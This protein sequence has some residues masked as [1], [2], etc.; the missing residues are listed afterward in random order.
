MLIS[1]WYKQEGGRSHKVLCN[2][3]HWDSSG[4]SNCW[5]QTTHTTWKCHKWK[6]FKVSVAAREG[7]LKKVWHFLKHTKHIFISIEM[8][9]LTSMRHLWQIRYCSML[10]YMSLVVR[11]PNR[12]DAATLFMIY[13]DF[14]YAKLC[15]WVWQWRQCDCSLSSCTGSQKIE[16]LGTLNTSF[17]SYKSEGKVAC[18]V[19]L[20]RLGQG[21]LVFFPPALE[22]RQTERHYHGL[23]SL[24]LRV[25][26]SMCACVC[27]CAHLCVQAWKEEKQ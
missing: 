23:G 8:L 22:I 15:H 1:L 16:L 24:W 6:P 21:H 4:V 13:E 11:V 14:V 19:F 17:A 26:L 5:I 27:V 12:N 18:G 2:K 10:R 20:V 3:E 9:S 7:F 25:C